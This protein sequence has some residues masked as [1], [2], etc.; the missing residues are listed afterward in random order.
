M[1]PVCSI[2]S[3]IVQL[4]PRLQFEAKVRHYNVGMPD[5]NAIEKWYQDKFNAGD[6]W[7]TKYVHLRRPA[8]ARLLN[9]MRR[10][11]CKR[12]LDVG[13]AYGIFVDMANTMGFEAHGLDLD[14][15]ELRRF[16]QTLAHSAGRFFHGS[17]NCAGVRDAV[18]ALNF[19]TIVATHTLR[20]LA[21]PSVLLDLQPAR[22]IISEV[23]N[24]ARRRKRRIRE[25]DVALY[26]PSD[27]LRHFPGYTI[28][29]LYVSRFLLGLCHPGRPL[30][31]LVNS[32]SPTYTVVMR[33]SVV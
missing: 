32:I 20:Y 15:P 26:S 6:A 1:N 23:S 28:E 5:A 16:H 13:C 22:F 21:D 7:F 9:A 12:I 30:C 19:D 3:Q 4:I 18:R 8:Y 27:L 11:P 33:R 24:T 29:Y 17:L 10:H 14:N 31:H 2:F 25:M